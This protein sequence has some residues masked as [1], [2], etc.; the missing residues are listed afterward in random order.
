MTSPQWE[1]IQ[2]HNKLIAEYMPR[3]L[4]GDRLATKIV[5]ETKRQRAKLCGFDLRRVVY[6][7]PQEQQTDPLE[8]FLMSRRGTNYGP[9]GIPS[10]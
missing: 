9:Q 7:V 1:E 6:E 8:R 2:R 4:A 5:T 10:A 3:A